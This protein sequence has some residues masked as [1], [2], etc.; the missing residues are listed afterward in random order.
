MY[1]STQNLKFA[2]CNI[3]KTQQNPN[4][5][6]VGKFC[7]NDFLQ[8]I[9]TEK[10]V[11]WIFEHRL[12]VLIDDFNSNSVITKTFFTFAGKSNIILSG[13]QS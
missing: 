9:G 2:T 10:L 5:Q 3:D 12:I 1:H 11:L 6:S 4:I 13:Y 8:L 7:M